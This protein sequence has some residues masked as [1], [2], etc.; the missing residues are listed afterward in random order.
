MR[1]KSKVVKVGEVEIGGSSLPVVQGM[2]KTDPLDVENIIDEIK[3]LQK[4]GAKLVRIAVPN[5]K[6]AR[7]ISFIREKVNLPLVADVHFNYRLALEAIDRGIDK[8]RINPGNLSF[9]EIALIAKKAK[10]NR[11]PLRVGVNSG[12]LP[13]ELIKKISNF[14]GKKEE[15]IRVIAE[16]MVDTA[17]NCIRMLED[18]GF[19]D[20][21]V[22]LKSS[23]IPV[24]ILSN[25][26]IAEKIP[27]PIHLGITATG[28]PPEGIIKSAIGIGALLSEGIGDTIRVSL[29][30]TS[31]EE[32]RIAYKILKHLNIIDS[33]PVIITCPTCGRC[34]GD[35]EVIAQEL[36]KVVE[37]IHF[38]IKIAVM[39]C[40]VNGP[41]EAMEA[42]IG[43]ACT[44][45]GGVLFKKGRLLN[46]VKKDR[47]LEALVREINQM[48]K[49]LKENLK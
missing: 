8:V 28:P 45:Q 12:S 49:E 21:V 27:Y 25:K 2:A 1:R 3:A 22:S 39:G 48:E 4:E 43:I 5:I 44:K 40:E 46:K 15:R 36:L 9:K 32:V 35:V 16:G 26:I 23:E 13:K 30:G 38:P 6:A 10:E 47:I 20:I 17:L 18:E 42:D 29:T 14:K 31:V 37:D 34:R 7:N 11:I 24:T 33:G 19:E 41:G